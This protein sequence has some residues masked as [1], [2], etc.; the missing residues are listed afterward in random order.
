MDLLVGK[1]KSH[2]IDDK[3][4]AVSAIDLASWDK[5][6]L[7]VKR[8][9]GVLPFEFWHMFFHVHELVVLGLLSFVEAIDEE[10][11]VDLV[12]NLRLLVVLQERTFEGADYFTRQTKKR[13]LAGL[14]R[15][16]CFAT[17]GS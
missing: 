4:I 14:L 10:L 13:R 15:H 16:L 8:V 2:G 3:W 17:K 12:S 9:H 7:L 11:I 6:D 5:T 1:K